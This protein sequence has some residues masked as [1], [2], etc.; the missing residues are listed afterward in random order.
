MFFH[1]NTIGTTLNFRVGPKPVKKFIMI[2]RHYFKNKL[3]KS[4]EFEVPFCMPSTVNSM[5]AIYE[6]PKFSN[7]DI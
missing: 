2:E 6:L 5:E 7:E 4:Y 3:I 1:L